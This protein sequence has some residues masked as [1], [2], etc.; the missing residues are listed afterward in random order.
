MS[1]VRRQE[2]LRLWPKGL[3]SRA[4]LLLLAP[5]F[6]LQ[7][8]LIAVF[9]FGHRQPLTNRLTGAVVN[10]L[11]LLITAFENQQ[12]NL[13]VRESDAGSEDLFVNLGA[14]QNLGIRAASVRGPVDLSLDRPVPLSTLDRQ[15]RRRLNA[16]FPGRDIAIDTRSRSNVAL[17]FVDQEVADG[18][19]ERH[20]FFTI[21]RGRLFSETGLNFLYLILVLGILILLPSLIF[22]RNQVRPI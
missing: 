3:L 20:Y 9:W 7:I 14:L 12:F 1:E 15:L 5:F 13:V 8:L 16:L 17:I 22:L 19:E 4:T 11:D 6:L 10:E 18:Q 2:G 21:A